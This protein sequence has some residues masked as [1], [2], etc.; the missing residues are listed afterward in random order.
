MRCSTKQWYEWARTLLGFGLIGAAAL[1]LAWAGTALEAHTVVIEGVKFEPETLTVKR[2][3]T[4][5]WVN[6]DPFP[7]TV[8]ASGVFDSHSIQ[9]GHSWKFVARRAGEYGYVCTLHPNMKG[10]LKVQ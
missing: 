4:V 6:K 1:P 3:E 7:H 10:T 9:A 8:T 2:G 5:R